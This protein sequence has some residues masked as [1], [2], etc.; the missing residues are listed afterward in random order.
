MA[1]M[2]IPFLLPVIGLIAISKYSPI[3]FSSV[4]Q[5]DSTSIIHL[6]DGNVVEWPTEKFTTDK[7]TKIHLVM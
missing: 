4:F 7:A 6:L 5:T 2:K 3:K 1:I